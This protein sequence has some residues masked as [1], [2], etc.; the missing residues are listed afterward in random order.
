MITTMTQ[1][2]FDNAFI[3]S[4]YQNNFTPLARLFL[5]EYLILEE[6][7]RGEDYVFETYS[8]T[9]EF[10]EFENWE[11]YFSQFGEWKKYKNLKELDQDYT[12]INITDWKDRPKGFI[13][14]NLND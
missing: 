11:D 10:T 2:C 12:I 5:Y 9:E 3:G 4:Q 14:Q 1:Q 13:V 8:I 6:D 7:M